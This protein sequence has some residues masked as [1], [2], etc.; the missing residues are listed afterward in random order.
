MRERLAGLIA[1][2]GWET[3]ITAIIVLNAATL[4]LETSEAVMGR[5][6][7]LLLAL[8]R[9]VLMVFVVEI[10]VRLYVHRLRFFRDAWSLFDF[11]IVAIA[12]VPASGPFQVLRALRIL[13][14]L[15]LVSMVP[16]LRRVVVGLIA[17]LPGMGSIVA[18]LGLVFY[19]SAVMATE[20]FGP[21]FPEWFGTLGRSAYTLFQVMT[22]ESWS[23]G[24]ARPVMEVVPYAFVFFVPFILL[25][26]FVVLN[27][28]I[29]V[30]VSAMQETVAEEVEAPDVA[31]ESHAIVAALAELK[32]EVEELRRTVERQRAA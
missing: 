14:V 18:L 2:R 25:T 22:L 31:E 17:A 19:I 6:G 20:L 7:P 30:V 32:V 3:A 29:G 12:L 21:A 26:A 9:I 15:R 1:S 13:R 16:S 23:M 28:F 10:G 27:L 8:D 11:A 24:I 5:V 4:G